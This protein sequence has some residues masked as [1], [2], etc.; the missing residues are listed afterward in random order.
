MSR[1]KDISSSSS[2]DCEEED[3]KEDTMEFELLTE[4]LN[5]KQ[6]IE[7]TKGSTKPDTRKLIAQ[8]I[9][10]NRD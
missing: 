5:K 9:S 6:Q 1:N 4:E 10:N 8:I 2:S 3:Q 7:L